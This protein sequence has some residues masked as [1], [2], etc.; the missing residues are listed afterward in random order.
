MRA[1]KTATT[2]GRRRQVRRT[3]CGLNLNG[4]LWPISEVGE[5][6][7][8]YRAVGSRI[9]LDQRESTLPANRSARALAE[10]IL[11]LTL[12]P[13]EPLPVGKKGDSFPLCVNELH[14]E[15]REHL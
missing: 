14:E 12:C 8:C 7:L 13:V 1:T 2:V 15:A 5:R 4:R 9:A 3:L 10:L 6:P 11:R